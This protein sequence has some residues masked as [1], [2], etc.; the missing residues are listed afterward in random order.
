MA[1]A[2]DRRNLPHSAVCSIRFPSREERSHGTYS[3]S[4]GLRNSRTRAT[5]LQTRR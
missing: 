5:G 3:G 2:N 1:P 4:I